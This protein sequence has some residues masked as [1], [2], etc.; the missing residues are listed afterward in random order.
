MKLIR[1][2]QDTQRLHMYKKCKT[3]IWRLKYTKQGTIVVIRSENATCNALT[4][5]LGMK[6][7]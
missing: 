7:Q 5:Y 6:M 4:M 3:N 2:K 1:N